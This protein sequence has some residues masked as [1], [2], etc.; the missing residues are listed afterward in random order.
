MRKH[1]RFAGLG[2]LMREKSFMVFYRSKFTYLKSARKGP[3]EVDTAM[4]ERMP[5]P[6]KRD[7]IVGKYSR[8]NSLNTMKKDYGSQR[9]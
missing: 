6:I 5:L 7:V 3:T 4:S 2:P 8:R 9:K 1:G